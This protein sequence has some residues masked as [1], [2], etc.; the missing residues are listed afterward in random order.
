MTTYLFQIETDDYRF[1][2]IKERGI[3]Y[4]YQV[5]VTVHSLEEA[6]KRLATIYN[7]NA[8]RTLIGTI[9]RGCPNLPG[10]EYQNLAWNRRMYLRRQEMK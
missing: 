10:V 4:C 2:H 3:D 5:R 8:K 1:T 7:G 9:K 6:I